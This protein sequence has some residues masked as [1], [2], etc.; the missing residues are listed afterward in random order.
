MNSNI[1]DKGENRSKETREFFPTD[2]R[3]SE[4]GGNHSKGTR[5]CQEKEQTA[6]ERLENFGR[7]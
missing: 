1:P 2:K 3:N 7:D 4:Q 6:R 5:E